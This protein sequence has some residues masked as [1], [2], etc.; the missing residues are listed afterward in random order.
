MRVDEIFLVEEIFDIQLRTQILADL[1]IK[2]A[3]DAGIAGQRYGVVSRGITLA[4][5]D[6]ADARAECRCTV[7]AVPER[8]AVLGQ[9][10]EP[11]VGRGQLAVLIR[12]GGRS[13]ERR[14]GKECVRTCRSRGWTY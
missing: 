4:L 6:D 1:I 7:I 10:G 3:I 5:V 8:S 14:V 12:I 13:E 2:R 11:L 9:V